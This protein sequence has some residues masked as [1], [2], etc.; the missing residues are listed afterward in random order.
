MR[1]ALIAA[2][3]MSMLLTTGLVLTLLE[4]PNWWCYDSLFSMLTCWG[5]MVLVWAAWAAVFFK[6]SRQDRPWTRAGR[7]V[8]GLVSGSILELFIATAVFAWNRHDEDCYCARGSY[9]GLVFGGTVL[10]WTFGPGIV[11]LFLLEKR[12]RAGL[13]GICGT[14]SYDLTGN[15]S[16]VCPECGKPIT[17]A[18]ARADAETL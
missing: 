18:P 4:I 5:G 15:T 16:G 2:A 11:W 9:T 17:G 8:R 1:A 7:I 12:R 14:C 10:V 6:Y 3:F 13:L